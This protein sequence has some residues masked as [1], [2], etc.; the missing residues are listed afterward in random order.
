MKHSS[1]EYDNYINFYPSEGKA[2]FSFINMV[3]FDK[4]DKN[5]LKMNKDGRFLL[6]FVI[7]N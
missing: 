7:L 6:N 5:K 2:V 3:Y 1:F 4:V